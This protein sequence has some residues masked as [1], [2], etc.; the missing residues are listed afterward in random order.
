MATTTL[1]TNDLNDLYLVDGQNLAI[2]SNVDAVLQDVRSATLMRLGEDIYNTSSGV[3]FF[4]TIF[5]PQQNYDAARESISNAILSSP[6]TISIERLD[7][8]IASETFSYQAFI[9]T[10]YGPIPVSV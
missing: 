5:T 6:D 7:V 3:D 4:G 8:T 9:N 2:I 1:K 10:V